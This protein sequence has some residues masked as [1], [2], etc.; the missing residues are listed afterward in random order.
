MLE[1]GYDTDVGECGDKLSTGEK[2][3]ISFA[4]AVI[5]NPKIFVLDEATSSVDT[6][7][8]MLIQKA[9]HADAGHNL[10]RHCAPAFDHPSSRRDSG[11]RPWQNRRAGHAREPA[12][13]ERRV[14]GLVSHPAEQTGFITGETQ[15]S[16][17]LFV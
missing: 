17:S 7:T 4:R 3:L 16:A 6:E 13:S 9:T 5:A 15:N 14:C 1:Q 2:Q 12:Q 11:H 8:E 10:V